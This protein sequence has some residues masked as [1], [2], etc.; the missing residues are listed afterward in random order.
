MST[1]QSHKRLKILI[2]IDYYLPGNNSGGPV[3]SVQN[4]VN[5]LSESIEFLIVT[6]NWD[7]SSE[8]EYATTTPNK[9]STYEKNKIYYVSKDKLTF[10]TI[11]DIINQVEYHSMYINGCYSLYFSIIPT[12]LGTKNKTILSL[13]GMID[14]HSLN[15]KKIKKILFLKVAN[16]FGLYKELIIHTTNNVETKNATKK[17][18][19]F[20]NIFEIPNLLGEYYI[21]KKDYPK[22]EELNFVCISR[23]SPEKGI[24]RLIKNLNQFNDIKINL[25]LYGPIKDINYWI[26]C[27]GSIRTKTNF[28]FNYKGI[29]KQS[30]VYETLSSNYD[31]FISF[32]Y[33]ENFGH[34]IAEAFQCGLPVIIS[35][36]TPW[37]NLRSKKIG[38]DIDPENKTAVLDTLREALII[39]KSGYKNWSNNCLEFIKKQGN[40]K[41][42]SLYFKLLRREL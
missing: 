8:D 32:T 18:K 15:Q 23:I 30:E 38:W 5:S 14:E 3:K 34:S 19:N 37:L 17:I 28:T 20:S 12:I 41:N 2:F 25:D 21:N 22:R 26:K 6:R 40:E 27:Q 33:G 16:F 10:K 1:E 35:N 29:L 36:K 24:E 7:Y 11:R 9:W 13:R 4:I 39:K 31:Y 42:I